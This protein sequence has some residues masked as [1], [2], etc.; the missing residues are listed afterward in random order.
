MINEQVFINAPLNFEKGVKI[1]PP[2]V[3]EVITQSYFPIFRKL[4]MSSQEDI[5]D[6]IEEKVKNK[7]LKIDKIPTPLEFLFSS[8][9]QDKRIEM[10][11][12]EGFR[13]FTHEEVTFLIEQKIVIIG[14]L[15][16]KLKTIN[17]IDELP[18]LNE[19]NFLKFQ[20]LLRQS[21]GEKIQEPPDPNEN[22]RIKRMKAKARLRDKIKAKQASKNG[23]AP[24]LSTL[25]AS[26]C[27]M[28][29]G[30]TPLNIGEISYAS[31]SAI[32][33][34]Y[35]AKEKY[36]VDIKSMLAGAKDVKLK[37]WIRDLDKD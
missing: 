11:A 8:I 12:K 27:C 4:L 23:E 25:L 24:S 1:Y 26:I 10:L 36:E 13:F 35:Q 29:I 3:K 6:D 19:T 2:T 32:M 28:G 15:E 17:N 30:L 34:R 18:I 21:I 31:V 7:E 33:E 14:N 20:N 22:P 16:K 37:Y 9:A 5:E